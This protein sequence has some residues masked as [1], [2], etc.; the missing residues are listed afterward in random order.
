M[1]RKV[2]SFILLIMTIFWTGCSAIG[3][4]SSD[5]E[6]ELT[7]EIKLHDNSL[8]PNEFLQEGVYKPLNYSTQQAMWFAYMDY[9]KILL[10]RTEEEFTKLVVE[11]FVK[12]KLLGINTVYVQV[13]AFCDAY[14]K[15]EL[16]P[17]GEYFSV[18]SN[19]DPLEIMINSAHSLNLSIHAW[20]NPMRAKTDMEMQAMSGDYLPKQWYDDEIKRGTY[21]VQVADRWYLN[22]AY[23][24]VKSF[25]TDGIKEIVSSY[26]VDGLHI[27]DYFYPTTDASFDTISFAEGNTNDLTAWRM[28]NINVM[29]KGI[30]STIKSLNTNVLF[31]ISPQGNV[32]KN[33]STQYA[34]V[35]KWCKEGGYCDYI[36]PQ[37]YFGFKN[38]TCPFEQTVFEWQQLTSGSKIRLVI[39]VC[40]YK[41]GKEDTWAGTGKD[42]WITDLN[43]TSREVEYVINDE[44]LSGV[45]IFS[46][47]STF[48]PSG[49]EVLVN[50]IADECEKIKQILV[51]E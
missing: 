2:V 4:S 5:L 6:M 22:P 12:A 32:E 37:I 28:E 45:A 21:I 50:A 18:S 34:D 31:G 11:R 20:V 1:R 51:K 7:S 49:D 48:E 47:N 26:E 39:G 25:I 44:K 27:D 23:S 15:S 30:Y 38:E 17:R 19:F 29:V 16:F 33:Y 3:N 24:E 14:Y 8:I 40:T 10:N 13:R 9:E 41:I 42:E 46:Y 43:V 36:V 35:R